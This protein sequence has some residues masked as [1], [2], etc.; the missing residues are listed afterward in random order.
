MSS[1]NPYAGSQDPAPQTSASGSNALKIFLIV[2]AVLIL[3]VALACTG[4]M[5]ADSTPSSV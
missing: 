4:I 2:M 3:I 1:S 5:F